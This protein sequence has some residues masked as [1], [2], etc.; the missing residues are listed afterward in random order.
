VRD[1]DVVGV[2]SSHA[3]IVYHVFKHIDGIPLDLTFRA[4]LSHDLNERACVIPRDCDWA[5]FNVARCFEDATHVR[6]CFWVRAGLERPHFLS[7]GVGVSSPFLVCDS[8]GVNELVY[9]RL[10]INFK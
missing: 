3:D 1:A 9:A 8:V 10:I 7:V 6:V 4:C 5:H 2:S